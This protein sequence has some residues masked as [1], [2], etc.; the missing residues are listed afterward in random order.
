[1]RTTILDVRDPSIF[2]GV[3]TGSGKGPGERSKRKAHG[4]PEEALTDTRDVPGE[5]RKRKAHGDPEEAPTDTRDVP[6]EQ[7]KRKARGD[8]EE[9]PTDTRDVPLK[10]RA[11]SKTK[12]SIPST[13]TTSSSS[14]RRT[15][16]PMPTRLANKIS[17]D[18]G[19]STA[20]QS[21]SVPATTEKTGKKKKLS[22]IP[23]SSPPPTHGP[24]EDD[25]P[26]VTREGE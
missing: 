25:H 14:R 21:T 24:T 22:V 16:T 9:A 19:A 17:E 18:T 2:T 26:D 10:K 3:D 15:A 12:S 8:P 5:Q 7:R 23:D 4:D 1:M 6:S 11:S 13:T 20:H